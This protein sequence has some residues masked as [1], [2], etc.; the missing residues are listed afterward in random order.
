[1]DNMNDDIFEST[2]KAIINFENI[3]E[4]LHG[5]N[6]VLKINLSH[7]N[8]YFQMGQDNIETLYQN[9]LELMLN[10]L[11]TIEFMKRLK[12]AEIDLDLPLDN[13]LK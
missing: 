9:L 3:K 6:E 5:I 8:I 11:G 12:N 1:M 4:C 10:E 13:L 2:K 7:E